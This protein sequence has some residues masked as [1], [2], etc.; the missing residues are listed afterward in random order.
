MNASEPTAAAAPDDGSEPDPV[1]SDV[2][3][4]QLD[5]EQLAAITA[6]LCQSASNIDP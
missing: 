2:I 5:P 3:V 6:S 4:E 1:P